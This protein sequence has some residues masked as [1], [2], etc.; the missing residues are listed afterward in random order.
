MENV[1]MKFYKSHINLLIVFVILVL[2]VVASPATPASA[3]TDGPYNPAVGTNETTIGTEPWQNPGE[4]ATP[5]SPYASVILYHL[6]LISN[7]LRGSQYGFALPPDASIVGIEVTVNR[8]AS[9]NNPAISDNAVRLVKGGIP[10]GA[11][12]ALADSWS[13]SLATAAYGGPTDLWGE[14]WTA[15][16]INSDTFGV[17]LSAIRDNN[18]NNNRIAIVDSMQI[19]VYYVYT[20][21]TVVECGDGTPV[22]YGESVLCVATVTRVAG[23]QTPSG[24]VAWSSDVV[25]SFSPNPCNLVGSAGVSTCSAAYT[26]RAVGTG[27]HT[28]TASY[29]GDSYFSPTSDEAVLVTSAV[30]VTAD[31]NSKFT[32]MD[33]ALTTSIPDLLVF[34]DIHRQPPDAQ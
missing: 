13:T 16:D 26:P 18:G 15:A 10:V 29:S 14:T 21:T 32:A 6:H 20:T 25:G 3:N 27:T 31:P 30:I 1:L 11:N 19:S 28:V 12:R 33:P 24:T 9:N 5:G 23:D 17:A 22:L 8:M 7:Y 4:I 2:S 34:T